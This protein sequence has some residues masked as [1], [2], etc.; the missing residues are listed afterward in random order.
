[1]WQECKDAWFMAY[2]YDLVDE[3]TMMCMESPEEGR[4]M[5]T[6]TGSETLKP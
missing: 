2:G 5:G 4:S 1:M 3:K 6:C